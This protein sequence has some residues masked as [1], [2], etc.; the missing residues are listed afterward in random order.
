MTAGGS[1]L[2][3]AI[4]LLLICVVSFLLVIFL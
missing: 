4:P 1:D 3:I 2:T